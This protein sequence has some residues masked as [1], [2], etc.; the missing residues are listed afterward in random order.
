MLFICGNS[1]K[2]RKGMLI[3]IE[4]IKNLKIFYSGGLLMMFCFKKFSSVTT[5]MMFMVFMFIPV[6]AFSAPCDMDP[7]FPS[8]NPAWQTFHLQWEKHWNGKNIDQ[9]V[10]ILKEIEKKDPDSTNLNLWLSRVYCLKGKR[11][12]GST[13]TESFKYAV[14]YAVKARELDK[15]NIL[16][17]KLLVDAA[18][19]IESYGAIASKYG[20][21][22]K[23]ISPQ[24]NVETVEPASNQPGWDTFARLWANR[25][26]IEKASKALKISE[27]WAKA[28]PG[29]GLLQVWAC[30]T[31]YCMGEY[32]TSMGEH[33]SKA[34]PYYKKGVVFG[35]NAAKIMPDSVPA[36]YWYNACLGR[37]VQTASLFTKASH[38]S[39]FFELVLFFW[40]ENS[41]YH[42]FGFNITM[43]PMITNGGWVTEKGMRMAGI[44]VE[45]V[46][47]S[48]DIAATIYPDYIQ[49]PYSK[50]L[51]LSY[52]G[53]KDEAMKILET[54]ISMNPDKGS[55][56]MAENRNNQ[57]LAKELY[58]KLKRS[59]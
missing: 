28:N 31:N 20:N 18:A 27:E 41:Q 12:S 53:K 34:V 8:N 15:D 44:T 42:Y 7:P 35:E 50:A 4:H 5:A 24:P 59:K 6:M 38:F 33:D 40:R 11:S 9:L 30:R 49:I 23:D 17:V 52:R 14:K 1:R 19:N 29:N 43:A 45:N 46:L 47:T 39:T 3:H 36:K 21:W 55:A 2:I 13:K 54:V 16:A 57:R 56:I 51:L 25:Y 58:T 48:L 32:W 22:I 10:S 26:D 37:S